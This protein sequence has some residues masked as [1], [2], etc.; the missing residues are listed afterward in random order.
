MLKFIAFSIE[1]GEHRYSENEE[2]E[3]KRLRQNGTRRPLTDDL[4]W[5][6]ENRDGFA[7]G[8]SGKGELP[9]VW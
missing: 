5:V 2:G 1:L 8:K 3:A 6:R 9:M 4:V 7:G